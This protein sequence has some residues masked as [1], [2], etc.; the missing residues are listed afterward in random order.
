MP[1]KASKA[2][3]QGAALTK[4]RAVRTELM[5]NLNLLTN[6]ADESIPHYSDLVSGV[7]K[8]TEACP[9]KYERRAAGVL[10]VLHMCM[11]VSFTKIDVP[12]TSIQVYDDGMLTMHI[13]AIW[14][15]REPIIAGIASRNEVKKAIGSKNV[16]NLILTE[17]RMIFSITN[18]V[19]IP[20]IDG[21]SLYWGETAWHAMRYFPHDVFVE[22][23]ENIVSCLLA[24]PK[25]PKLDKFKGILAYGDDRWMPKGYG[26]E[27]FTEDLRENRHKFTETKD[28][29]DEPL[30]R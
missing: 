3:D 17:D 16:Q 30:I 9:E 11:P 23:C 21:G 7:P 14:G 12:L 28:A 22:Y 8:D 15:K 27:D 2:R 13:R 19:D 26:C 20:D 6:P 10:T 24:L 5:V 4:D 29:T 1:S 18:E 25:L